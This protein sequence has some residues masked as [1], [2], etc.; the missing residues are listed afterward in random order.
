VSRGREHWNWAA[1]FVGAEFVALL[2][3]T[4]S[5]WAIR[6]TQLHGQFHNDVTVGATIVSVA[7]VVSLLATWLLGTRSAVAPAA[8][9][10][11]AG[12]AGTVGYFW[13]YINHWSAFTHTTWPVKMNS[14]ALSAVPVML[15][16]LALG[17]RRVG[18]QRRGSA[19]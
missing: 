12:V 15:G 13:V 7:A 16:A 11:L 1:G 10:F 9:A 2:S 4:A 19:A 18:K 14:I 17:L 5:S 8:F 6:Q 3:L